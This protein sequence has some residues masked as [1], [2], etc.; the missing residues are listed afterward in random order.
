[1]LRC[2]VAGATTNTHIGHY[3]AHQALSALTFTV[4]SATRTDKTKLYT[5]GPVRRSRK[6]FCAYTDS[7]VLV[8]LPDACDP[9]ILIQMQ[10]AHHA[11]TGH[12]SV[13][14]E[15]LVRKRT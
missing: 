5:N 7:S 11:L 6:R 9:H 2:A 15:I 13:T 3:V 10:I 1:M 8:R 14:T 4:L 12:A